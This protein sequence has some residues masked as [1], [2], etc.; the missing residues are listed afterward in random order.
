[1]PSSS[2]SPSPSPEPSSRQTTPDADSTQPQTRVDRLLEGLAAFDETK[3]LKQYV[4][5]SHLSYKHCILTHTSG[6]YP[7]MD[8]MHTQARWVTRRLGLFKTLYHTIAHGMRLYDA[9]EADTFEDFEEIA[10][11]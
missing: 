1:M 6:K 8:I 2:P 9:D 3:R 4:T 10:E 11:M 5:S 7:D